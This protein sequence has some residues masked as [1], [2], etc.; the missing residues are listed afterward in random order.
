MCKFSSKS[1]GDSREGSL[2][3]SVQKQSEISSEDREAVLRH[4]VD[5]YLLIK[6]MTFGWERVEKLLEPNKDKLTEIQLKLKNIDSK[7]M[8]LRCK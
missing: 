6:R 1:Q 7:Q 5:V 2:V 3:R 4:P 8:N